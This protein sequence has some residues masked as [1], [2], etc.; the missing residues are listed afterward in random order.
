MEYNEEVGINLSIVVVGF[1][2]NPVAKLLW[3]EASEESTE[4][5]NVGSKVIIDVDSTP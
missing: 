3:N 4:G 2:R 1:I 5:M